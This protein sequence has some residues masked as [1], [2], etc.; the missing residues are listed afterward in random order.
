MN[1]TELESQIREITRRARAA[2][3]CLALCD[4]TARHRL[5]MRIADGLNA[6]SAEVLAENEN[7]LT[8]G[9]QAGLPDAMLDRLKLDEGRL[10]R[11]AES[12]R[13]VAALPD[14]LGA[15]IREWRLDNGIQMSKVRVPIGVIGIIYE[16]RPNVT[17]DAGVL[18]LKTGNV[19]VLRGGKEALH[20][21]RIL[22]EVM[23]RAATDEGLPPE[24]VS[25]LPMTG[26]EAIPVFCRMEEYVDLMI[27]RGGT[28]LIRTVVEH[29]RMPVIKHYNGICHL[30]V[31]ERAEM[32]M[33]RALVINAKCQRPGVCNALETLLVDRS[34]AGEF[35][36]AMTAELEARGV[37]IC[38]DPESARAAGR[39]WPEPESW[40]MEYLDLILAVRVVNNWQEAVGHIEEYGSHHTDTIVTADEEVARQFLAR[41]DSASVFWNASTR[42][43]D[44]GQ[45]G[46]GAEIGISTDKIHA[47]GP[48]GLEELTSYKYVGVGSGQVR[49]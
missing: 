32:A 18:C 11:L 25:F 21:N 49:T 26:R 30:Y 2:S 17:V 27:P 44:G 36:P 22:A 15:V 4:A 43:S 6:A 31:H 23:Q 9:K 48:M 14:P 10:K 39:S 42:F 1:S 20:S 8:Q 19:P 13:E 16:S 41:V 33:A 12:V 5:L 38:G 29:A 46:F 40:E 37:K 24:V 28:G 47:R 7:D 34:V 35:L 3:K 45:F